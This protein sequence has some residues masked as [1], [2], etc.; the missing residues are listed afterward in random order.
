MDGE[1][2]G[3]GVGKGQSA[4]CAYK[5][6]SKKCTGNPVSSISQ[7]LLSGLDFPALIITFDHIFKI[8]TQT[9]LK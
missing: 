7:E 2:R 6:R 5:G 8:Y 4:R 1:G 3:A 9:S